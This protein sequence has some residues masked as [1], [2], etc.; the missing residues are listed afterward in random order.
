[1]RKAAVFRDVDPSSR[2]VPLVIE[3][4]CGQGSFRAS[5]AGEGEHCVLIYKL[6][7]TLAVCICDS[8][9]FKDNCAKLQSLKISPWTPLFS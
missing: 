2:S 3:T 1:M 9:L 5:E 7:F 8:I 4:S 6:D